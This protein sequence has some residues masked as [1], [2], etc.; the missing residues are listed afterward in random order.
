MGSRL[1]FGRGKPKR[2]RQR[3]GMKAD[4]AEDD[5]EDGMEREVTD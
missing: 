5:S 1:D 4:D 2:E 3:E